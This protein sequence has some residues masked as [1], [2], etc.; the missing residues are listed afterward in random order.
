MSRQQ[1]SSAT[2]GGHHAQDFTVFESLP[3]PLHSAQKLPTFCRAGK[4]SS[5]TS[6]R[7]VQ[8]GFATQ[9]INVPMSLGGLAKRHPPLTDNRAAGYA[10]KGRNESAKLGRK[11]PRGCGSAKP[12][13]RAKRSNPESLLG[14]GS[15]RRGACHPARIRA[16]RWLLAMTAAAHSP[17][18]A[19]LV[20]NCALGAATQ[21][22]RD[23]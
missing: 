6:G 18:V 9:R 10:L 12:S 2:Q 1:L 5:R 8:E 11:V 22:S 21:Y 23:I 19:R 17:V 4:C 3:G 20:R 13:L 15:L 14:S 16:T 7:D